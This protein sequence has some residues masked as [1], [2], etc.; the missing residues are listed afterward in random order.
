MK[1]KKLY[2]ALVFIF[3]SFLNLHSKPYVIIVSFDGFRWDYLNR[4]I[5]PNL[6]EILNDGVH[7]LSLRPSFPSKTFPNHISILTGMYP[8]NHGIISNN[9]KNIFNGKRYRIG[10]NKSVTEP[11]WYQGEF[12]WE[13]AERNGIKTGKDSNQV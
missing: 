11:E 9:I 8:D 5:T 3:I 2:F 12:F 6:N 13:T 1:I 4:N 7:A 10:N